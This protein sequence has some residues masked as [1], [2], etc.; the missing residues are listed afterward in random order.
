MTTS[1]KPTLSTESA[2]FVG[3]THGD[4]G[5]LKFVV[6]PTAVKMGIK[7]IVQVG[8]IGYWPAGRKFFQVVKTARERYGVDIWFIDGNHE[9]FPKLN[10][11]VRAAQ[12]AASVLEGNRDPVEL[13]PGFFYLPRGSRVSVAGKIVAL[14]GGAASIDRADRI[15]GT[16]WF[17]EER[18]SDSDIEVVAAG[19]HADILVMHDAPSGYDIPGLPPESQRPNSWI[20]ELP[21]CDEHRERVREVLELVTP[22]VLI[23]GHYHAAYERTH[24]ES[25]GSLKTYGLDRNTHR[26]W[27][28]VMREVD[29]E[30]LFRW[31]DDDS[32]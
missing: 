25:W 28:V 13:T 15:A 24:V 9:H 7:T 11:D 26:G 4:A 22:S 10:L 18:I 30:P 6:L 17:P 1:G 29:R 32:Q 3:D 14:C 21:S 27:G 20:L 2:L 23:H 19:G 31:V 12:V 16:D 8:D 5:W